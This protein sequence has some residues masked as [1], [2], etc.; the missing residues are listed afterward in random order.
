MRNPNSP[1]FTSHAPLDEL[2]EAL[3]WRADR[4]W[5]SDLDLLDAVVAAEEVAGWLADRRRYD[6]RYHKG[7][8]TEA[9]KEFTA[10]LP[11]LGP[12]VQA[13]LQPQLQG[14]QAALAGF[15]GAADDPDREPVKLALGALRRRWAE[16]PVL[17]AAWQDLLAAC[18]DEE[19]C[20]DTIAARRDLFWRLARL[21]DWPPG[22]LSSALCSL[23]DGSVADVTCARVQ[24]DD[25][26]PPPYEQW[27]EQDQRSDLPDEDILELA[28]RLLLLRPQPARHVIW[29]A[30]VNAASALTMK[31]I[32]PV[33]LVD[34]AW[35]RARLEDGSPHLLEA[36]PAELRQW[37]GEAGYRHVPEGDDVVMARVDLGDGAFADPVETARERLHA[38]VGLAGFRAG[39]SEWTP[40]EG[41]LHAI[42]GAISGWQ[43]F[44][45]VGSERRRPQ[46]EPMG[47]L[48]GELIVKLW[49]Q[50]AGA[51]KDLR[52]TAGAVHWW[53][54]AQ[55]QQPLSA[56][57]L[58]VRVIEVTAARVST[59]GWTSYLDTYLASAWI[60]AIIFDHLV[61]VIG[62]ALRDP[63]GKAVGHHAELG[64]L[65]R[66]IEAGNAPGLT[67]FDGVAAVKALPRLIELYPLH[68]RAGRRLRLLEGRLAS[69]AALAGWA[70]DV[71]ARW[72]AARARLRR[73]RNAVAHG[74]PVTSD[75]TAT[76]DQVS[77]YLSAWS[78]SLLLDGDKAGGQ[79]ADP[80]EQFRREADAWRAG[81]RTAPEVLQALFTD[82]T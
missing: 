19:A 40:L 59:L 1:R 12:A 13:V 50:L 56:L 38:L 43:V 26:D 57:V 63:E 14:A 20:A 75:V 45:L 15:P 17:D 3:G 51:D 81:L 7:P 18:R 66:D 29:L 22:E 28:R 31:Q 10:A 23:L 77:R 55:Q 32:G 5:W 48:L 52:E 9:I 49:E 24:L 2:R 11:R 41:Y 21:T 60:R 33:T 54:A 16:P 64:L 53:Q 70:D 65:R 71:A 67:G 8:W 35:L 37:R 47:R 25:I 76:L 39:R 80:H 34:G 61:R 62:E 79:L 44:R 68:C 4:P 58:N 30:F 27:G 69:P 72:E 6:K 36:L 73:A 78:L 42:D 74:G 82:A 46:A